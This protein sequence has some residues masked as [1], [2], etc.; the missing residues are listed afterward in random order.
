MLSAARVKA[1]ERGGPS[2]LADRLEDKARAP[3]PA[4]TPRTVG[5]EMM[6]S[7]DFVEKTLPA[8]LDTLASPDA[9]SADASR[10]RLDLAQQAGSLEMSLDT[11]DSIQAADGLE[12]MLAHQMATAHVAAMK[13]AGVMNGLLD[14][15]GKTRGA[16]QQAA[17][18]EANR[19]AGAYARLTGSF[20][21][22]MQT[23]Q[24]VRSGGRQVVVV[25]HNHINEGAQAV[26][27]GAVGGGAARRKR[28][29]G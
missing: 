5:G 12:R 15:A 22:G 19:M 28:V 11:A 6:P 9:V 3:V 29:R 21:A 25:Q 10:D 24:R 26:V 17:C 27:T 1:E 13:A 8:I 23:L 14:Y 2:G 18:I 4:E 7:D 20:Q 16:E